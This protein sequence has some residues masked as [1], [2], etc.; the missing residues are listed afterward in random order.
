MFRRFIVPFLVLF[1]RAL[2]AGRD[3]GELRLS[4]ADPS[5]APVNASGSLVSRG[6]QFSEKFATGAAGRY[7]FKGLAFGA[8]EIHV[9]CAGF[10]PYTKTVSVRSEV[11]L[12][13]HAALELAGVET[14]VVVNEPST[15]IDP[16]ATGS[17]YRLGSDTLRD[18]AA[19]QPSRDLANLIDQQPGWLLEANGVL[20]PRGSEYATQFVVDGVPLTENLSPAFAPALEADDYQSVSILTGNYPA[21][22]GRKLGGVIEL[23]TAH[24]AQDGFHG[25]VVTGGGSFGTADGY[26]SGEY[27]KGR[28]S[29]GFSLNGS[30]T[31]RYLDPPVLENFTN[32]GSNYGFR[33]RAEHD[34]SDRDRVTASVEHSESAFEVPNELAQQAAG[35]LQ[36]R[37]DVET[38]G[39][40]AWQHVFTPNIAANVNAMGRDFAAGLSSNGFSTPVIPFQQRGIRESYFNASVSGNQGRHHWKTGAE[41]SFGSISENLSYAI[42]DPTQFDPGTPPS[43]AFSERRQ[44]R[45]QG[46]FGQDEIHAGRFT[47]SAGLRWDHYRLMV[48]ESAWS[49]RLGAAW[50]FASVGLAL[51][52]SYDRTFETPAVE[53]LLLASSPLVDTL[54]GAVLR[55]PVRPAHGNYYQAGFTQSVFGK[56][57]LDANWYR[58]D[59]VNYADDDTLL[60]TGVSFPIS[61][62][63]AR[64]QGYEARLA[65][66]RVGPLSG[67]LSYSNM[68]GVGFLPVTGGLFLNPDA[69]LL[70]TASSFP[71]SQDQR[72]SA[73]GQM[74]YQ[75]LP[76]LWFSVGASYGSG[77]PVEIDSPPLPGQYDP[78]VL[79]RVNF[80]A[81]RV[82]PSFSLDLSAGADV[83]KRE[84]RSLR[85]QADVINATDRLNVINFASLFSGTAIGQPRGISLRSQ[86]DF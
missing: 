18:R 10:V 70:R 83:W 8:Y 4:V 21:E 24:D 12:E 42:A 71:V 41:A 57:R 67:F 33:G 58:R 6:N 56:L 39:Q 76:R 72:N 5:G 23:S 27:S 73:H 3:T 68:A 59:F 15:L 82:R 55:V 22:F 14:T 34:F 62:A 80:S 37:G 36:D 60:N 20:H 11:P 51:H 16:H 40:I 75:A 28:S 30:L 74:R 35:Q 78:R 31:D 48:D 26:A 19:A 25:K 38:M 81:G 66:P 86:F 69:G 84:K 65:L 32:H 50:S 53:N 46:F 7:T 1:T 61:F 64:I 54:A 44:D 63:R 79:D 17:A 2:F 43:F 85:V 49:P 29:A 9:D 52:A 47:L 45:E 77:L 13:V